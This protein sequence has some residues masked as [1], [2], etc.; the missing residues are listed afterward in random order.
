MKKLLCHLGSMKPSENLRL[1]SVQLIYYKWVGVYNG[2]TKKEYENSNANVIFNQ[3]QV[4]KIFLSLFVHSLKFWGGGGG[5][6][7]LSP[8]FS[9]I[10]AM[11]FSNGMDTCSIKGF[12]YLLGEVSMCQ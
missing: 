1:Q 11:D 2:R 4:N 5:E 6:Q 12:L 7:A 9:P 8:P 10:S 3:K